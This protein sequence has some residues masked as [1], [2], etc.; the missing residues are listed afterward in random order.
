M[1]TDPRYADA[2]NFK[3]EREPDGIKQHDAGAKLDSGKPDASMLLMFGKAFEAVAQVATVGAKKYSRGGWQFVAEGKERYTAAMLRH[4]FKEHYEDNDA[5][6]GLLHS[7]QVCWNS[8]ARLEL[9]LREL[10]NE[11]D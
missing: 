9:Q 6:T 7:A 1:S 10:D 2:L 11:K 5:D 4:L 3:L 8:L